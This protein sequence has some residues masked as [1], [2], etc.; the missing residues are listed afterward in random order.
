MVRHIF[1][2]ET[3]KPNQTTEEAKNVDD[4]ITQFK[5][6]I[7]NEKEKMQQTMNDA[8]VGLNKLKMKVNNAHKFADFKLH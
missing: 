8:L 3:E 7:D 2:Q 4:K 1:A 6:Q 5:L